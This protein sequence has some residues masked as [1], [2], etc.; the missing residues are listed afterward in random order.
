MSYTVC[1]I[2]SADIRPMYDE[3]TIPVLRSTV[4]VEN[5]HTKENLCNLNIYYKIPDGLL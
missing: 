2:V 1:R 4:K 5:T 3:H